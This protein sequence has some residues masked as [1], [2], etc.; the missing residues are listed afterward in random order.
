MESASF[1]GGDLM[2][3][4][5]HLKITLSVKTD[6]NVLW[7]EIREIKG[8]HLGGSG[9]DYLVIFDG[10]HED[11]LGVLRKCMQMSSVGKIFGDYGI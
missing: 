1:L 9:Q 4:I 7:D 11:G 2:Q 10:K 5:I 6:L 8:V 3:D